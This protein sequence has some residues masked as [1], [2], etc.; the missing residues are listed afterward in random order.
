MT[1]LTSLA[2]LVAIAVLV[3]GVLGLLVPYLTAVLVALRG[4]V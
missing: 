1:T 4:V 2:L 3:V